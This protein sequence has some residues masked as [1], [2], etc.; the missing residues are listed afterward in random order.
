M[1]SIKF[2]VVLM[3]RSKTYLIGSEARNKPLFFFFFF[4]FLG[5]HLQQREIPGPGFKRDLQLP[6]YTT[7]TATLDLNPLSQARN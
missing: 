2:G 4:F 3:G 7:A 6:A 1:R 5:L